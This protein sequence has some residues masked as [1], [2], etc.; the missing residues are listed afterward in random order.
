MYIED[1]LRSAL[2]ALDAVL[3]PASESAKVENVKMFIREVIEAVEANR[4]IK[5]QEATQKAE[6][7][8]GHED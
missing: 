7:E 5:A 8:E 1:A 6:K 4:R 3:I 2:S